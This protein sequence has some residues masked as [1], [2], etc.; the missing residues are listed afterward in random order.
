MIAMGDFLFIQSRILSAG[1]DKKNQ[2]PLEK[3]IEKHRGA[4]EEKANKP[5]VSHRPRN[6]GDNQDRK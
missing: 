5:V 1:V 3:Q 6:R 4:L 2:S